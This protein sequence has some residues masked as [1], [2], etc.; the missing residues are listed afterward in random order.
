MYDIE[1][2]Y[3]A[4]TIKEAVTLLKE[5]LD[6]RVISGGSD[7]LIKI[8]EGKMAGTSLVSIRDIKE[9][10]GVRLMESGDIYIGAGT[11]FSHVTNDPVIQKL[12][13]VLGEAVDLADPKSVILVLLAEMSAMV[14]S[15]QTVHL[16]F[17]H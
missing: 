11:T 7:V 3:N 15:V 5:H 9:I 13:P 12:I 14:R 8:R 1:N 16:H 17:F 2:Y 10:K 6:A 4:E